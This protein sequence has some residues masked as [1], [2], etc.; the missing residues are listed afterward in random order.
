MATPVAAPTD[1]ARTIRSYIAENILFV[2]GDLPCGDDDSFLEQGII[3]ST[4][5]LELQL[6]IEET[7]G[8]EVGNDELLPE[9][10][11]SIARLTRYV[12]EKIEKANR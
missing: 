4:G 10:F 3:D 12:T 7:F 2:D 1:V 8:F 9:N 11:D 5:I 6:F